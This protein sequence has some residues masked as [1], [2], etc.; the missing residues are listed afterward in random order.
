MINRIKVN[1]QFQNIQDFRF[2]TAD[3]DLNSGAVDDIARS[4]ANFFEEFPARDEI[5]SGNNWIDQGDNEGDLQEA[6]LVNPKDI[7]KR[8]QIPFFI[9][10]FYLD[11]THGSNNGTTTHVPMMCL[12]QT[13]ENVSDQPSGGDSWMDDLPGILY[14][15]VGVYTVKV[16]VKWDEI[17]EKPGEKRFNEYWQLTSDPSEDLSENGIHVEVHAP[18]NKV[19]CVMGEIEPRSNS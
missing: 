10:G 2:A 4:I 15:P 18:D 14:T 16:W 5:A 17:N 6:D 1:N 8:I 19:Y 9:N 11:L 7:Y 13:T 12:L 3:L